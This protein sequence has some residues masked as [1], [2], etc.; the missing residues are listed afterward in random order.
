MISKVKRQRYKESARRLAILHKET[1]DLNNWEDIWN[2]NDKYL[3]ISY[4]YVIGEEN[5][6]KVKIGRS[7][8]PGFRLRAL[9]TGYPTKLYIFAY[10]P[11]DKELNEKTIHRTFTQFRL[12]G[13]WFNNTEEIQKITAQ[14]KGRGLSLFPNK[15]C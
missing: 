4:V 14:I 9:Q 3:P 10:C 5:A 8:N 11:E 15:Q 7:E 12:K 6:D 13:E 2:I 1:I